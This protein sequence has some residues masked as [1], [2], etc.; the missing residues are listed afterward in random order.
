MKRYYS[1]ENFRNDT[2]KLISEVKTFEAE[3]IV[4]VARGGLTLAHCMAEGLDIRDVQSIRT[5]LYDKEC[6]REELSLFGECSLKYAKRVLIVDDIADSGET[7]NFI[8]NYLRKDFPAI[9]FKS[10]ALFYK[11]TSIYEPDFWI[12]EADI[13]IEFFWEKDFI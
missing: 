7:L 8:M 4:A 3:A 11:K 6:K 1:Y 9:E 5:E 12:N 10:S 2:C 13:W